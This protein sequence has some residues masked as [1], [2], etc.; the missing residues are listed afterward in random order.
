MQHSS[1]GNGNG[2]R[3]L[4]ATRDL[5]RDFQLGGETIHAVDRVTVD[6]PAG[7]MVVIRGRSGSG[8]T[9]LLN[10]IAGL[11]EPTGGEIWIDGRQTTG[12]SERERVALRREKMGFV[13]QAFGLLPLLSARE[14]VEVPLRIVK[15]ER[16]EREARSAAALE[17][18]G[19]GKRAQHRPYELSGG[20]QQRVA[21]AR[22]LVNQPRIILADEPTGQLD[23]NTGRE[24][25]A[26]MR[27][28]VEQQRITLLVVTHDPV[29]T[30]A[31]DIVH[32]LR[33]GKLVS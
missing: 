19:L 7:Q 10:L 16:A 9:T 15:A 23:S 12:L 14:N 25:I 11:D 21:L 13:F 6:I 24:I 17:A 8:K 32:E 33:D 2:T 22:A 28:L 20:E 18:V 27:R 1:Y 29:V 31:A 5:R 3:P 26:L 4:I 30:E